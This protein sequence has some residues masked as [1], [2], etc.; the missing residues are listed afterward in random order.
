MAAVVVFLV[1]PVV[2]FLS[3]VML[4]AGRPALV[5]VGVAALA[6][7][8]LAPLV[9]PEDGAGFGTLLRWLFGGAVALGGFVQALRLVRLPGGAVVP[10]PLVVTLCLLGAVITTAVYLGLS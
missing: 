6:V 5:G 2:T 1:L 7:A 8:I 3:L 4:P 9:A 10:Y